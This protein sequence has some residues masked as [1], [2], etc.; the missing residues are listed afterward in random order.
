MKVA[1]SGIHR[2]FQW[3]EI[4]GIRLKQTTSSKNDI[5]VPTLFRE[6]Y[7]M[8]F[9]HVIACSNE[10]CD[11]AI[12]TITIAQ[13]GP[14]CCCLGR[15]CLDCQKSSLSCKEHSPFCLFRALSSMYY[16]VPQHLTP[17]KTF[18]VK[19]V[20]RVSRVNNESLARWFHFW[21]RWRYLS[22]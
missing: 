11:S 15:W 1:L 10:G 5:I 19:S 6:Q 20:H 16:R 12:I 4:A 21:S 22:P 17:K 14:F 9:G 3:F 2:W 18:G 7:V 13:Y 8:V